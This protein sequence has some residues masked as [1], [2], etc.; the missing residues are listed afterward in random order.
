MRQRENKYFKEGLSNPWIWDILD[1][2]NRNLWVETREGGIYFF[3]RK[4]LY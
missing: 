3:L 4:N 2:E 1:N